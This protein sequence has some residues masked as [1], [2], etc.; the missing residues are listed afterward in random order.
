MKKITYRN[1]ILVLNLLQKH[2]KIYTKHKKITLEHIKDKYKHM[3]CFA[4]SKS[5]H[6]MNSREISILSRNTSYT[7]KA[8]S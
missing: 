5:N 8:I 1:T 7:I 3:T 6:G 4:L 2:T